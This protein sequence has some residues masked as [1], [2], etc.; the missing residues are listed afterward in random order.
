[1]VIEEKKITRRT[2]DDVGNRRKDNE[3]KLNEKDDGSEK[4]MKREYKGKIKT[5]LMGREN[6]SKKKDGDREE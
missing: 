3:K 1:M 4:M 2:E 6:E 5:A